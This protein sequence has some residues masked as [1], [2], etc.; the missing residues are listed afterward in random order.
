MPRLTEPWKTTSWAASSQCALISGVRRIARQTA[1]DSTSSGETFTSANSRSSR[2]RSTSFMVRV[3]S[4]VIHSVT[5]GIGEG[6]VDHRLPH[7]LADAL[8]RLAPVDERRRAVRCAAV[9]AVGAGIGSCG[10]DAMLALP[11]RGLEVRHRDDPAGPDGVTEREVDAELAGELAH[12]RLGEHPPTDQAPEART[13]A[14]RSV[15]AGRGRR[16]PAP[17]RP[18]RPRRCR[19]GRARTSP[20]PASGRPSR[21]RSGRWPARGGPASGGAGLRAVADER[22]VLRRPPTGWTGPSRAAAAGGGRGSR[23]LPEPRT[24]A[25]RRRRRWR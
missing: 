22:G 10:P 6:R 1:R 3:T 18:G 13:S 9:P 5:C 4:T 14:E 20:A 11:A 7:H 8:D 17:R 25:P 24:P 2:S 21:P 16:A 12:R 23:G 15:S 19:P